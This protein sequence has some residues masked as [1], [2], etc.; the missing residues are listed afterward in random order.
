MIT[1]TPSSS[2]TRAA[3]TRLACCCCIVTVKTSSCSPPSHRGTTLYTKF[4]NV[5]LL[6]NFQREITVELICEI[7]SPSPLE[8]CE[9]DVLMT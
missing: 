7:F 9:L 1:C 4:P 5:S 6:F 2:S 8:M 3:R